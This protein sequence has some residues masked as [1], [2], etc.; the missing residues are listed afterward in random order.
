VKGDSKDKTRAWVDVTR[1]TKNES[2]FD[3]HVRI[4]HDDGIITGIYFHDGTR[5]VTMGHPVHRFDGCL[6]GAF[7]ETK[8]ISGFFVHPKLQVPDA[9]LSLD[10]LIGNVSFFCF[11]DGNMRKLVKVHVQ[12]H[13]Q[14]FTV[15]EK[16]IKRISIRYDYFPDSTMT[17]MG[18][19]FTSV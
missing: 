18:L 19:A 16:R 4:T 14:D 17:G 15:R 7:D 11:G 5:N 8:K 13:V 2:L 3:P 6:I 9:I 1:S 10:L 12:G